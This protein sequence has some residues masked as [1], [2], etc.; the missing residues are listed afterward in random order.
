MCDNY[1]LWRGRRLEYLEG[2]TIA[3]VPITPLL[4]PICP[5]VL[6]PPVPWPSSSVLPS[7]LPLPLTF[8]LF[9]LPAL[10]P[11]VP[12]PFHHHHLSYDELQDN[13]SR[14]P[15]MIFFSLR[16]LSSPAGVEVE[17]CVQITLRAVLLFVLRRE[18]TIHLSGTQ[19]RFTHQMYMEQILSHA[20]GM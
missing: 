15:L 3:P 20:D 17:K 10:P 13:F 19:R 12:R 6:S 4:S 18:R 5:R 2:T 11:P 9:S 14:N 1:A 7:A 8:S 16:D